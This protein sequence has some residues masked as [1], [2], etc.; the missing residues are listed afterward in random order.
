M[1]QMPGIMLALLLAVPAWLLGQAVP[2]VGGPVFAILLGILLAG[3]KRPES[4]EPGLRFTG[5][6]VLQLSIV[7]LGFEM[8]L[9]YVLQVG[10]QSL[11]IIVAT[12]SAAFLTAWL[13]GRW[14]RLPGDTTILIGVGT[15][16]CGG[17]AIAATAPVIGAK[18]QDVTYSISTIFLFNIVAVFLFPFLGH[19]LGL[20]DAC[21]GMWAGT[22][23]NDTSSVVAAGYS[24]SDA[25]GSYA[26]IVKLTRTLMIIPITLALG[27]YQAKKSRQAGEGFSL[28]RVFPLFVLGFL[29]ASIVS[30]SGVLRETAA[31]F[32]GETGKFCIAV[33]MAAIGLNTRLRELLKNGLAPILLGLACWAAVAVVSLLCQHMIGLW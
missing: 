29:A 27:L 16:I 17:S 5:K 13:V 9:H 1:K 32:L 22:A 19:L 12:L 3:W 24:Y 11:V 31:H 10:G 18:T 8:N 20:G 4:V 2:L 6:K 21:F 26:T 14:L 28:G 33:A 25:A 30:T 15:A 23:I 7:L